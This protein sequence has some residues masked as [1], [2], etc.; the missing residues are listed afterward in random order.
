MKIQNVEVESHGG[1]SL[2]EVISE[3]VKGKTQTLK[4]KSWLLYPAASVARDWRAQLKME[5]TCFS[6]KESPLALGRRVLKRYSEGDCLRKHQQTGNPQ[7]VSRQQEQVLDPSPS[8]LV[9]SLTGTFQET[10]GQCLQSSSPESQILIED[11]EW[12]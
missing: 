12:V 2:C 9:P 6:Q 10:S 8:P 3:L 1:E 5:L 4:R 11:K 7:G